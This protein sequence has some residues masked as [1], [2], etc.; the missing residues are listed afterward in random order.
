MLFCFE[1]YRRIAGAIQNS[2]FLQERLFTIARF[3]NREAHVHIPETV[4]GEHCFI[5]GSIAPPDDHLV[6]FTL[7]AHT[8]KQQGARRVTGVLPYLAYARQDKVKV[9]ES[10]AAAWAGSLLKA[11]GVD[12]I[13]TVDVHSERDKELFAVPLVSLSPEKLFAAE[14]DAHSLRDGTIVAPDHGAVPRC[15]ALKQAVGIQGTITPHFDKRRTEQGIVHSDLIGEVGPRVILVDDILDTGGT[16]V[17][18]CERL[19]RAKVD[20]IYIFITHGLFTGQHWKKLWDLRVRHIFCTDTKNPPKRAGKG[21]ILWQV[22][23]LRY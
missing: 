13:I 20:E 22:L 21:E 15:E 1:D 19:M 9:G 10:L 3:D 14:I 23:K 8:L 2:R 17:S 6:S 4:E 5:L 7:L 16:L 12:Q 11:S 18:A